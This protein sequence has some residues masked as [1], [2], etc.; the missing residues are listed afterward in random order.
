MI[1]EMF[2]D[3]NDGS[4]SIKTIMCDEDSTLI[5][6]LWTKIVT[7]IGKTLDDNHVKEIIVTL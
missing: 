1:E 3:V 4:V 6:K 5:S 7:N 2:K